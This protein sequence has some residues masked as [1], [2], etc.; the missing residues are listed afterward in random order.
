MEGA[1]DEGQ[2]LDVAE[3]MV[4]DD[5]VVI[6]LMVV[7]AMVAAVAVVVVVV[8]II[9][10]SL[11]SLVVTPVTVEKVTSNGSISAALLSTKPLPPQPPAA[12]VP[13]APPAVVPAAPPAVPAPT[14]PTAKA[15]VRASR[16]TG[17]RKGGRAIENPPMTPIS[18]SRTVLTGKFDWA[19]SFLTGRLDWARSVLTGGISVSTV[20]VAV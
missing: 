6:K 16:C 3:T 14:A 9:I 19:R 11:V 7:V 18:M 8:V 5:D 1:T 20:V 13:A 10:A 15:D 4:G 17:L 2:G 12:V